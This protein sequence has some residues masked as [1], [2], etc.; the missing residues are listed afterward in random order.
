MTK[1][2]LR[3]HSP[4]NCEVY[5][6]RGGTLRHVASGALADLD[7]ARVTDCILGPD[8]FLWSQVDL[9]ADGFTPDADT[10][11]FASATILPV[12][13]IAFLPP[14]YNDQTQEWTQIWV[15]REKLAHLF[16]AVP[17]LQVVRAERNAILPPRGVTQDMIQWS[18]GGT[19]IGCWDGSQITY[20]PTSSQTTASD[21]ASNVHATLDGFRINT[22][23]PAF[24]R[25]T[26][27]RHGLILGLLAGAL[28]LGLPWLD[29]IAMQFMSPPPKPVQFDNQIGIERVLD[30]I[31]PIVT[32]MELQDITI[33]AGAGTVTLGLGP[34]RIWP[35]DQIDALS[36]L[37]ASRGCQIIGPTPPNAPTITLRGLK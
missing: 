1:E 33:S 17:S 3:F 22:R 13:Q 24:D 7:T 4:Q 36:Q 21:Q 11:L 19:H 29:I 5:R 10:F 26:R 8:Q 23:A 15:L 28:C 14:K 31:A 25:G 30:E 12:D 27:G 6:L 34:D 37:C 2:I 18:A 20:Q 32:G 35:K 16:D 9:D